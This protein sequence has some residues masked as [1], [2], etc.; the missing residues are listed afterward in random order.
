[1]KRKHARRTTRRGGPLNEDYGRL[2]TKS[3]ALDD[4]RRKRR[5]TPEIIL[6]NVHTFTTATTLKNSTMKSY[7]LLW[8]NVVVEMTKHHFQHS[9]LQ[10]ICFARQ[11]RLWKSTWCHIFVRN[12]LL[13]Y[14]SSKS[15]IR[16][17]CR[18]ESRTSK[19]TS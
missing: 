13:H 18:R 15:N 5:I 14:T 1:M 19:M 4:C 3:K 11:F 8:K 2:G 12:C 10:Q 16:A 7:S 17:R 9:S 6:Y